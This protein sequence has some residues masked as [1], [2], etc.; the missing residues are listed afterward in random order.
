MLSIS[1][2]NRVCVLTFERVTVIT[3]QPGSTLSRSLIWVHST[4]MSYPQGLL[5][6]TGGG[7]SI[8]AQYYRRQK[9]ENV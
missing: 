4:V 1:M 6:N 9:F 2:Y 3:V 8:E 7:L 5:L